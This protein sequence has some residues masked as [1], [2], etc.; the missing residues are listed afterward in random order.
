MKVEDLRIGQRIFLHDGTGGVIVALFD[1][2]YRYR[3]GFLDF[4]YVTETGQYRE[5]ELHEIKQVK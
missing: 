1:E 4:C 2:K 3:E 5:A